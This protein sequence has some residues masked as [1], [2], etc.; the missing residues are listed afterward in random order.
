[1]LDGYNIHIQMKD[2][3]R[4]VCYLMMLSVAEVTGTGS[5]KR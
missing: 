5:K 3:E 2:R 4:E 1:M